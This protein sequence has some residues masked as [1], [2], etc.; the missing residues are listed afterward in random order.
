MRLVVIGTSH[1]SPESVKRI[2]QTI[3]EQ[4][5]QA[6]AIEL[7]AQ[8]LA[9]LFNQ[10]TKSDW[11]MIRKVGLQGYIFALIGSYVQKKLAKHIG[12]QPGDDMRAAVRAARKQHIPL[13]LIDQP[14][15]ITLRRISQVFTWREKLRVFADVVRAAL[16]PKRELKKR[17][18]E[19]FDLKKVP[20]KDVIAKLI[21]DLRE[22]YPSLYKVLIEE[23]NQYMVRKL[24]EIAPKYDGLVVVVVG[25]GHEEGMLELLKQHTKKQSSSQHSKMP[26]R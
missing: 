18:L 10:E 19:Q 2:E 6:V 9:S 21:K 22:R 12:M 23:R 25:A 3:R 4:D 5:V 13:E 26:E 15:Y 24:R 17:G 20:S 8:R 11:R 7:D 16:F 1:I 14:I